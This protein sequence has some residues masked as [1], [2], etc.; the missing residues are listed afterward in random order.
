MI[1]DTKEDFL[2]IGVELVAPSPYAVHTDC[3]ICLK[4]LA[5]FA[6]APPTQHNGTSFINSVD[7]TAST[8]VASSARKPIFH[9]A[10][11]I[12]ACRHVHGTECLTAWLETGNTCPKCSRILFT[13]LDEQPI[14]Q[15]EV[16]WVMQELAPLL[17]DE[18]L[19]RW[20]AKHMA[21]GM[22]EEAR[23]KMVHGT[24]MAIERASQDQ[25]VREEREM[26]ALGDGDFVEEGNE[27]FLSDVGELDEDEEWSEE[28]DLDDEEGY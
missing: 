13:P 5:I 26:Y 4:P 25:R 8:S 14:N 17:G 23:K 1:Y 12:L 15:Q 19:Y 18:V 3:E 2:A 11:R 21:R 7:L 9:P 22:A 6:D 28:E 10:L 16:D 20:I 24:M 27:E